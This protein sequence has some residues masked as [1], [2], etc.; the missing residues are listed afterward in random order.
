MQ[1]Q[2]QQRQGHQPEEEPTPVPSSPLDLSAPAVPLPA[3][4]TS[5]GGGS[6]GSDAGSSV[7]S[8]SGAASTTSSAASGACAEWAVD[9]VC[10]FVAGIESCEEYE[11]VRRE[12]NLFSDAIR[13]V[14]GPDL[15]KVV[16]NSGETVGFFIRGEKGDM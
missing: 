5:P 11:Q 12:R 14:N 4:Q 9:D 16:G 8:S 10:K 3:Q 6:T 15:K 2:Q 13:V 7:S 1:Q